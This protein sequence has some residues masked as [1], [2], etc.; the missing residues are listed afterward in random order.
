ME[1][2]EFLKALLDELKS[3]NQSQKEISQTLKLLSRSEIERR[4]SH[5]FGNSYELIIYQLTNG[6][7]PTTEISKHVPISTQTI[8][9]LWQK[10]EELEIV[11]TEGYRNP[12]RTKYSLEELALLFGIPHI[13][14]KDERK[15]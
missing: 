2:E 11:E 12:Y 13:E 5:I 1:N 10:W 14:E 4:L 9:K 15:E 3:L 6:E 8:S 7:N